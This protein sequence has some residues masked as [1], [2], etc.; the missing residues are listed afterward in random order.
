[1]RVRGRA[2]GLLSTQRWFQRFSALG[3]ATFALGG[4]A[5]ASPYM[6]CG[7]DESV[8]CNYC[9]MNDCDRP[10]TSPDPACKVGRALWSIEANADVCSAQGISDPDSYCQAQVP[11]FPLK[12]CVSYR[13]PTAAEQPNGLDDN[14]DG[15]GVGDEFCDGVDNDGDGMIDEDAGSCLLRLLFVPHCWEAG[16]TQAQARAI[17]DDW[18]AFFEEKWLVQSCGQQAPHRRIQF[19]VAPV[20]T[21]GCPAVTEASDL[22]ALPETQALEPEQ[23]DAVSFFTNAPDNGCIGGL[24]ASGMLITLS[25]TDFDGRYETFTHEMGHKFGL[26]EE[27]R[28]DDTAPNEVRAELGCDPTTCCVFDHPVCT[29]LKGQMCLG[30]E[31][32][33]TTG[34]RWSHD[35]SGNPILTGPGGAQ[36]SYTP[37]GDGS[38][39]IMSNASAPGWDKAD[40]PVTGEGSHRSFCRACLEHLADSNLQCDTPFHGTRLIMSAA[41]KMGPN[42]KI[43]LT[44]AITGEGRVPPAPLPSSGPIRIEVTDFNGALITAFAPQ[45]QGSEPAPPAAVKSFWIREPVEPAVAEEPITFRSYDG[46]TLLAQTTLQGA[47]PTLEVE[48]VI[49]ECASPNGAVVTLDASASSDPDGDTLNFDWSS[50]VALT[51]EDGPTS[52]GSFP[53]GVTSVSVELSDGAT[54]VSG[55]LS[56]TVQDTTAPT[57]DVPSP[58]SLTRTTCGSQGAIQLPVPTAHDVCSDVSVT[59]A[60]VQSSTPGMALPHEI[61]AG[62]VVL[63]PGTHKVRWTATDLAGNSADQ[64]Q[65]VV[66]MPGLLASGSAV[67]AD[68]AT[69]KSGAAY[70]ALFNFGTELTRVGVEA[71]AGSVI[72]QA[73]IDLRD[74]ASVHGFARTAGTVLFGTGASVTGTV[75]QQ[76]NPGLPSI[77][78]PA[79]TPA[80]SAPVTV[81]PGAARTLA[82]GAYADV[83]VK[84]RGRLTLAAGHYSFHSF[85][86]ETDATVVRQGNVTLSVQTGLVARGTASGNGSLTIAYGGSNQV[87]LGQDLHASVFAKNAELAVRGAVTGTLWAKSL[88]IDAG[89]LYSCSASPSGTPPLVQTLAAPLAAP[90]L[91]LGTQP[92]TTTAPGAGGDAGCTITSRQRGRGVVAW[93]AIAFGAALLRRRSAWR[94][95]YGRALRTK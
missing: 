42:G 86:F 80:G 22:L 20:D 50:S 82:P 25:A 2:G 95:R 26:G 14:C 76:V 19:D 12:Q 65:T 7:L 66:V 28:V 9:Y 3:I 40:D 32:V 87:V 92:P 64:E 33:D 78:W 74:R 69:L 36:P 31:A 63:P 15:I 72:S 13:S 79:L 11:D 75:Q 44:H 8:C 37:Y 21:L 58:P 61:T 89:S 62:S 41:G 46:T 54:S 4:T 1:M 6:T 90:L 91:Q 48:S 16:T 27:Y 83:S 93:L 30:N 81:E 68:R 18:V 43:V 47:P 60:V 55:D 24:S 34:Y 51:P 70:A 67:V 23:Y 77:P 84:S 53:I 71:H 56:V 85:A 59:G 35:S 88:L 49:A 10:T 5:Q 57:F 29:F 73:S 94:S 39:C 52:E 38:R 45:T 17:V